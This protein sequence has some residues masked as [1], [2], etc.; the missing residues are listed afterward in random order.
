MVEI[1]ILGLNLGSDNGGINGNNLGLIVGKNLRNMEKRRRLINVCPG[2]MADFI[3]KRKV[4][5]TLD[6]NLGR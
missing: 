6:N 5:I 4:I 3:D 2:V 1:N